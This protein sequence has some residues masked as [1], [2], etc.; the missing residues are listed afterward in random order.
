MNDDKLALKGCIEMVSMALYMAIL[1]SQKKGRKSWLEKG[2]TKSIAQ[3]K[4][5]EFLQSDLADKWIWGISSYY[6]FNAQYVQQEL[7]RRFGGMTLELSQT[8]TDIFEN[9]IQELKTSYMF[10]SDLEKK[11]SGYS[12]DSFRKYLNKKGLKIKHS[13]KTKGRRYWL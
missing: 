4:A 8:K 9:L 7:E 12:Y 2:E 11:L 1:E 13:S 10:K 6:G 3:A 5:V